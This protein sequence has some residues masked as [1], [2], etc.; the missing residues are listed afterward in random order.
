MNSRRRFLK[1]VA[2]GA[3]AVPGTAAPAVAGDEPA[4][5]PTPGQALSDFVRARFGRHLT[6]AQLKSAQR[7]V[8]GLLRTAETIK[9]VQLENAEEPA[10]IFVAE[11]EE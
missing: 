10:F 11:P 9:R 4:A 1:T 7:E 2:A 6:E 5:P 3:A 8:D